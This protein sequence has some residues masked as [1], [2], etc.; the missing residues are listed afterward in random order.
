[1]KPGIGGHTKTWFCMSNFLSYA[2]ALIPNLAKKSLIT[3]DQQVLFTKGL[4][5]LLI[6]D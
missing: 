3:E 6:E 4:K 2:K 1:M 5:D